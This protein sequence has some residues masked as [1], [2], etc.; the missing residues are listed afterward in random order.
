MTPADRSAFA[1]LDLVPGAPWPVVHATWRDLVKRHHPDVAGEDDLRLRDIN[2]AYSHLCRRA[3][4][5]EDGPGRLM[6]RRRGAIPRRALWDLVWDA[7]RW[8]SWMPG[9]QHAERATGTC[10]QRRSVSGTWAGHR[11]TLMIVLT[12]VMPP[13]KLI[14][15]VLSMRIDGRLVDLGLP[16][17]VAIVLRDG[18]DG[19]DV[20]ISI[21]LPSGHAM[22]AVMQAALQAALVELLDLAAPLELPAPADWRRAA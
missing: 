9:V 6:C 3:A 5:L 8:S 7:R 22:P 10:D 13:C 4:T 2:A 21:V 16:P 15:R 17:K 18:G 11:F 19:T 20:E 14:G 1:A 12:S